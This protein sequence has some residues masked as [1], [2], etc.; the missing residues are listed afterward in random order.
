MIYFLALSTLFSILVG[1]AAA[2]V[3]QETA[4][5]LFGYALFAFGIGFAFFLIKKHFDAA[6]AARH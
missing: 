3:A 5:A 6:D 1:L 2:S 4:F